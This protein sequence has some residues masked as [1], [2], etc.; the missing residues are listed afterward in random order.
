[1]KETEIAMLIKVIYDARPHSVADC[2]PYII[3]IEYLKRIG[4]MDEIGRIT[5][6][7][8]NLIKECKVEISDLNKYKK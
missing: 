7:G 8:L 1:M 4:Y 5:E 6:K 3:L 2:Y